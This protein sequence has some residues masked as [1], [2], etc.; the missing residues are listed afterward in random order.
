MRGGREDEKLQRSWTPYRVD[1]LGIEWK[2]LEWSP[3][4]CGRTQDNRMKSDRTRASTTRK[5]AHT[6]T[7]THFS[8]LGSDLSSTGAV[9]VM[10]CVMATTTSAMD[11][12]WTVVR[13][14]VESG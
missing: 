12:I 3:C 6:R 7:R 4:Q 14:L 8:T 10:V 2:A 5:T 1:G 11:R 13:G 9:T